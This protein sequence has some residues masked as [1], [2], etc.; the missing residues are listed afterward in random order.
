MRRLIKRR[1]FWEK[2]FRRLWRRYGYRAM[3][4]CVSLNAWGMTS[5]FLQPAPRP[6]SSEG[7][8]ISA[9]TGNSVQRSPAQSIPNQKFCDDLYASVCRKKGVTRDPTGVVYRDIDGELMALRKYEDIIRKHPDWSPEQVDDEL[10]KQLYTKKRT[11]RFRA[12][13]DWVKTTLE[14][15]IREEPENLFSDSDKKL[16]IER[17]HSVELQFPPPASIYDDEPDLFTK[18]DVY[19]ERTESA[20]LRMRVGGAFI[21]AVRSWFNLV[22]TI[23]HELGHSIDPCELKN[24]GWSF[25]A[26]NRLTQ[27]F[28]DQKISRPNGNCESDDQLSET[29]AD[30]IAVQVTAKA[31][32][33]YAQEFDPAQIRAAAINSVRDLCEDEGDS[34]H[35]A[36]TSAHPDPV[37]RIRKIFGNH[38]QI[39]R[40]LGC[41]AEDVSLEPH[42]HWNGSLPL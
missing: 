19:F 36:D 18:M 28:V 13:F 23:T 29:F 30:W 21:M 14:A 31:L 25:P 34:L 20:K 32:A 12:T 37:Q 2:Y 22:F 4:V 42:C 6:Y 8:T 11:D 33:K 26:Y 35:D 9:H 40:L 16:I 41:P 39:R 17:I 10:A 27:C 1:S 38:P 15:L 7:E 3:V 5:F 24:L